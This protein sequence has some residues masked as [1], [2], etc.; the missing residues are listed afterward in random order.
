MPKSQFNV[1]VVLEI[2]PGVLLV[3]TP[4]IA[5]NMKIRLPR[6]PPQKQHKRLAQSKPTAPASPR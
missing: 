4:E 3:I 2:F 5:R 1:E 6:P